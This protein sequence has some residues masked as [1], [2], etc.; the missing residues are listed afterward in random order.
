MSAL[1]PPPGSVVDILAVGNALIDLTVEVDD[2]AIR[3][4]ALPKGDMLLTDAARFRHIL[5]D[6]GAPTR[7]SYG[8]TACNTAA[9]M[10][11]FGRSAA[12]IGKVADD[13]LG[14]M[15][16]RQL[17]AAQVAFPTASL[18]GPHAT[19]CCLILVTPDGQRTGVTHL[20]AC[21]ELGEDDVADREPGSIRVVL[22]EAYLLDRPRS[23]KAFDRAL[24]LARRCGARTALTLADPYCVARNR[25]RLR[26][27]VTAGAV[28]VLFANEAEILALT[29]AGAAEAALRTL[30]PSVP[31]CAVTRGAQGSMIQAG[32]R[33]R[34]TPA[35]AANVV[36]ATGAGDLYAA[37]VLTGLLAGLD[38]A[39]AS[40]LGAASAAE[41]VSHFTARPAVPLAPLLAAHISRLGPGRPD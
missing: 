37:G 24:A 36:D 2:A 1:S 12:F 6:V 27:I 14:T 7:V 23:A 33:I 8:G 29:E 32:G 41:A 39:D 5:D 13:D 15:L 20:G 18:P 11:A 30:A 17:A 26:A 34:S 4:H 25:A 35:M 3:R 9:G 22:T 21:G 10:A 19:A 40:M 31:I 38:V 16:R 28:D